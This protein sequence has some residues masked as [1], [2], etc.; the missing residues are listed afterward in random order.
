MKNRF[1]L[2]IAA[3]IMLSLVACDKVKDSLP[4]IEIPVNQETSITLNIPVGDTTFVI[5]KQETIGVIK[6]LKDN[7]D[8]L[9]SIQADSVTFDF[10]DLTGGAGGDGTNASFEG[11]IKTYVGSIADQNSILSLLI[12]SAGGGSGKVNL[13]TLVDQPE[14]TVSSANTEKIVDFI[15]TLATTGATLITQVDGSAA[16][17]SSE[18]Y[19]V[20]LTFT[21]HGK[22]T[23]KP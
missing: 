9:E 20:K 23:A 1:G 3:A 17:T 13:R 15:N 16:N 12:G 4:S 2:S 11:E 22:A 14:T 18:A 5:S 7:A 8:K 21:I 6:D 19:N 10:S